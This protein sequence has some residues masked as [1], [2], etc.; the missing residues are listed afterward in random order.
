MEVKEAEEIVLFGK[1]QGRIEGRENR[2]VVEEVHGTYI[3]VQ[4]KYD[5]CELVCVGLEKK[6]VPQKN[7]KQQKEWA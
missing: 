4:K 6:C 1:E 2:L 3:L 7:L 5:C